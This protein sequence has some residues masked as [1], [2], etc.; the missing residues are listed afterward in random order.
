M[1]LA[2]L[3]L[4]MYFSVIYFKNTDEDSKEEWRFFPFVIIVMCSNVFATL[5][6]IIDFFV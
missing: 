5:W 1:F 3:N 2:I 4:I 6:T